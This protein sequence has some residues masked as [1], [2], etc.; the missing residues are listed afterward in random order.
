MMMRLLLL[1]LALLF[2]EANTAVFQGHVATNKRD[3]LI[4]SPLPAEY[5]DDASIP[6]HWDWRNV[7]GVSY[8]TSDVNQHIP[9]YCGSCWIHGTVAALNDRIKIKRQGQFPDVMLSRQ[10]V[11]NCAKN[12]SDVAPGCLGG[13]PWMV[14]KLMLREPVPDESCQP[15]EAKNSVCTPWH[16]C[17]NCDANDSVGCFPVPQNKDKGFAGYKITEYGPVKGIKNIMKE[18]YERGPV[19][20]SYFA[21]DEFVYNYT[22]NVNANDGIFTDDT[23]YSQD[24]VDH[25]VEVVG[26][27]VSSSS[28]VPYWIV[29]NSWGTYWGE[30]GWFKIKMGTLYIE[31]DCWWAN[32]TTHEI[33]SYLN[34]EYL[35]SYNK[36]LVEQDVEVR[37]DYRPKECHRTK[38]SLVT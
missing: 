26:W 14:F 15:Y 23:V 18:I 1:T 36:G 29:R 9:Q 19:T 5:L 28:G 22:Q 35:G 10:M 21:T 4:I 17:R 3:S 2:R 13:E 11:V 12:E 33:E 20:C 34:G 38:P 30:L 31:D 32:P 27:D 16:V 37:R 24:M 6:E 25:D 8:V 7:D